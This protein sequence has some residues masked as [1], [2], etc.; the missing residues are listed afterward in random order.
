[1]TEERKVLIIGLDGAEPSLVFKW[2]KEGKLPNIA[3]LMENGA[4]GKLKSTI[5]PITGPAWVSFMTGKNPGKHGIYHFLQRKKNSYQR[6]LV[7]SKSINGKTLWR[8]LSDA[9]LKVGVVN[10]PLTYPP[11]KVNGFIVSGYLT[12]SEKVRFTYP[13]DLQNELL[14][15]GYKIDIDPKI[16]GSKEK[17]IKEV[18]EVT[19]IQFKV[20]TRLMKKIDWNLFFIVFRGPDELQHFFWEE[21]EVIENY[22]KFLDS[23]IGTM[24][25]KLEDTLVVIVSDHG[26]GPLRKDFCINSW[27]LQKGLL[28]IKKERKYSILRNIGITKETILNIMKK[29]KLFEFSKIIPKKLKEQIPEK[30]FT[31]LEIDWQKTK[32]WSLGY[33]GQIYINLKGRE[34]QGIVE[35]G[36]EYENLRNYIINELYKLKDPETGEKVIDKIYKKEEIYWGENLD[37]APDVILMAREGYREAVFGKDQRVL[38]ISDRKGTHRLYGII[39][40]SGQYIKNNFD[41]NAEIVDI[42]PTILYYFGLPIPKDVDGRVLK[43]I[44]EEEFKNQ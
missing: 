33:N 38:D 31:E 2:A 11:E 4:Y 44:F 3:K 10:V 23:L 29:F 32:T 21:F 37:K 36:E 16:Y 13:Y 26:F 12:P 39:I 8:I 43:E 18:Y 24:V 42:F 27:L 17:F 9:G 5:P 22:Y 6:K 35:P 41:V 15:L 14:A 34:P 25:K 28:K 30:R 19:K 1:M 7:S 40:V 20:A